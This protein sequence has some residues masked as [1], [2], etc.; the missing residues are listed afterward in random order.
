MLIKKDGDQLRHGVFPILAAHHIFEG[1]PSQLLAPG[2]LQQGGQAG[3]LAADE[4][5]DQEACLTGSAYQSC[6]LAQPAAW[7][8]TREA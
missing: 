6:D 7:R 4:Q 3:Q 2:L 1:E 5:A 8:K